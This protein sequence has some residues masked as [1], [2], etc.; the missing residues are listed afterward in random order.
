MDKERTHRRGGI[1]FDL[2][3]LVE[4]LTY[5]MHIVLWQT[6][7]DLLFRNVYSAYKYVKSD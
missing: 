1:R 2:H 3:V 4:D 6:D 5:P 7:V